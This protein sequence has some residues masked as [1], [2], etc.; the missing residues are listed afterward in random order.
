MVVKEA[1]M[2]GEFNTTFMF[3]RFLG[4]GFWG[5]QGELGEKAIK[6]QYKALTNINFH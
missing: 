3:F 5:M 1:I 6:R 2:G 4:G